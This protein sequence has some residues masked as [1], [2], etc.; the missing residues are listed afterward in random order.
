[1]L[2][3]L[4][5]M[6]AWAISTSGLDSARGDTDEEGIRRAALDYCEGWYNGDAERMER[7]LHP[8]LA[9]RIVRTDP[10]TGRSKLDQMGALHVLAV[11]FTGVKSIR[12][13][14]TE[15]THGCCIGT[16]RHLI[17]GIQQIRPGEITIEVVTN[18]ARHQ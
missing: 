11:I 3:L 8:E 1:M 2:K 18:P 17:Q 10:E 4:I 6:V 5:L 15:S 13:R 9:K 14:V 16:Q 7:S 12:L